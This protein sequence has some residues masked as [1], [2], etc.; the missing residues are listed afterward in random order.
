MPELSAYRWRCEQCAQIVVRTAHQ[1]VIHLL[2]ERAEDLDGCTI[3]H[4]TP[5]IIDRSDL[6]PV[7]VTEYLRAMR[8][9]DH[10]IALQ[11]TGER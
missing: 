4:V 8:D 6:P 3:Q 2:L 11:L 5:P 7:T 10:W 1:R 9:V